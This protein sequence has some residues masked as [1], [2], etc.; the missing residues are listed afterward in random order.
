[1]PLLDMVTTQGHRVRVEWDA[2]LVRVAVDDAVAWL[3]R[4][5][6]RYFAHEVM[7]T[8]DTERAE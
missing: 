1:M 6:A 7:L 4:S 5:E 8:A 2:P 3:T